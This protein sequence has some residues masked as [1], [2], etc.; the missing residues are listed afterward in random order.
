MK[1]IFPTLQILRLV[2]Q[3]MFFIFLPSLYIQAFSGIKQIYIALSSHSFSLELL[4]QIIEAIVL[5]PATALLGRFF[6]GWMC[7]FGAIIDFAY[8]IFQKVFKYE[9]RVS[10]KI[11]KYLKY[12]KYILLLFLICAVWSFNITL[13]KSANPW[14]VFGMIAILGKKPD[15]MGVTSNALVGLFIFIVIMIVSVFIER[16]FCRYLCPMGAIFAVVSKIRL[17]KIKKPREHCGG[18]KICTEACTMDIPLYQKDIVNDN[19]CIQCMKCIDACPKNNVSYTPDKK[20]MSSVIIGIM[21]VMLITASYFIA[22]YFINSYAAQIPEQQSSSEENSQTMYKD[23]VY[24][25][26]GK[27]FRGS[28]TTVSVTI[29]NGKIANISTISYGDDKPYYERAYSKISSEIITKQSVDVDSVSGA[30]FSS[31]GIKEAVANALSQAK[32]E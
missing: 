3:I 29:K 8:R 7:G 32:K 12:M 22:D 10:E 16:F 15:F 18:C 2:F 20:M 26:T 6:C 25:G 21:S 14:D 17:L 1:K 9:I 4:P 30:T 13:F 5:L 28:T 24:Q 11:D 27:G 31:R 23:G 19:E